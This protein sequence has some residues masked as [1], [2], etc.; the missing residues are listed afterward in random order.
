M[1]DRSPPTTP[2]ARAWT[3]TLPK[4][5][6]STGPASTG[7]PSASEVSWHSSSLCAPPPTRCT[8]ST[9]RPESRSA[10]DQPPHDKQ[11]R[12]CP[13]CSGRP[14]L[15]P[16]VGPDRSGGMTRRCAR[17]CRRAAG[18]PGSSGSMT[19]AEGRRAAA[20]SRS[21]S[22]SS[23]ARPAPVARCAAHSCSSHSPI[24]LRRYRTVA[25]DA[26]LVGEVRRPAL[27]G[28]HRLIEL[29]ADQ[30]PGAAGDVGEPFAGGR[31]R[32]P[33]PMPCRAS[34]PRSRGSVQQVRSRRARPASDSPAGSPGRRISGGNRLAGTPTLLQ[35]VGGP[36]SGRGRR[37]GAS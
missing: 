18:T 5:A 30:G 25:V 15:D 27:L 9:S 26:D 24:T 7:N 1:A 12:D 34:R 6:A 16:W 33:P 14:V 35:Q 11:A 20:A 4:A 10:S 17:A 23:T 3:S 37:A 28:E 36:G 29:H 31:A 19:A 22:S 13:Q 32:R 21:R 8:T 2:R